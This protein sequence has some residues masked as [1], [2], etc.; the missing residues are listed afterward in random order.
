MTA[1]A[2]LSRAIALTPAELAHLADL[3]RRSRAQAGD[4]RLDAHRELG[5][6]GDADEKVARMHV[7]VVQRAALIVAG[8]GLTAE[9]ELLAADAIAA[10]CVGF[11]LEGTLSRPARSFLV[12]V[13]RR[14]LEDLATPLTADAGPA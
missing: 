9:E 10:G 6:L 1:D 8:K 14:L 13:W 4:A 3:E 5:D 7:M 12:R 11:R 2:V